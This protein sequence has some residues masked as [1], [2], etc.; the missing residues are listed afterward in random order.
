MAQTFGILGFLLALLSLFLASELMR[1]ASHNQI[2]LE[3]A[4]FKAITRI[5]QI[6]SSMAQVDR[7][8]AEVRYEKK[9]QAETINALA[10]KGEIKT[11]SAAASSPAQNH[12]DSDRFTP[13]AYKSKSAG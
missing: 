2:K 9:R 13:S 5:Q 6:E 8:A 3:L 7:L 12:A 11:A 10:Q 1:R 4:L